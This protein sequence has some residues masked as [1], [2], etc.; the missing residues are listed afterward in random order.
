MTKH[1]RRLKCRERLATYRKS[2]VSVVLTK[3]SV[4][5]IDKM[6]SWIAAKTGT[7][8]ATRPDVL[9][10]AVVGLWFVFQATAETAKPQVAPEALVETVS[11]VIPAPQLGIVVTVEGNDNVARC[12][13][14]YRTTALPRREAPLRLEGANVWVDS[15]TTLVV[16]FDQVDPRK[17]SIKATGYA[18]DKNSYEWKRSLGDADVRQEFGALVK[19]LDPDHAADLLRAVGFSYPI[20]PTVNP[21]HCSH[22]PIT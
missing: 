20:P 13:N 22:T 16:R 4:D 9:S 12:N 5:Q 11:P 15:P 1:E 17:D 7:R 6:K 10:Q 3:D 14:E 2:H 18:R 8:T 21:Q 19:I